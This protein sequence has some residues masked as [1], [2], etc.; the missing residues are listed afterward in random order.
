MPVQ[1]LVCT[2]RPCCHRRTC[3]SCSDRENVFHCG[4]TGIWLHPSP[5]SATSTGSGCH[6]EF[7]TQSTPATASVGDAYALSVNTPY[8][9]EIEATQN[10]WSV[11]LNDELLYDAAETARTL[12][13]STPC[14]LSDPWYGA[15]AA[16]VD[17]SNI[18]ARHT[19][20]S[21]FI[22]TLREPYI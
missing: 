11:R 20:G 18:L 14:Y 22:V 10:S 7:S 2:L 13:N 1:Q 12:Y 17:F 19:T 15:G 9:L 6:V 21:Y 16:D 3:A 5:S 8:H 4:D